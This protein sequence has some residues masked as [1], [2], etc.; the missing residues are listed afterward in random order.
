MNRYRNRAWIKTKGE[1]MK[2]GELCNREVVVIEGGASIREAA[3]LMRHYHVGDVI[4]TEK[5]EEG[6]APIGI[7][8]DRDI[9][10]E[11]LAEDLSLDDICIAD[12][13]SFELLT[14]RTEDDAVE[15]IKQMRATGIR[16]IPVVNDQGLLEG[17]LAVDDYLE[18][19]AEQMA[20]LVALVK[21]E[22]RREQKI[23]P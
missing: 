20:D 7:L 23:R 22:Q 19:F 12:A 11:L 18:F 5:R 2:V 8:T 4:V 14:A 13:M 1:I 21:N 10:V 9:V 6:L 3:K 15:T 17:L 16:R